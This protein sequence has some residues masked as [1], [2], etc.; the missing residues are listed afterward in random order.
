MEPKQS[1]S[2]NILLERTF[3]NTYPL[4][5]LFCFVEVLCEPMYLFQPSVNKEELKEYLNLIDVGETKTLEIKL[6]QWIKQGNT[7][8]E[9]SNTESN[10]LTA[11][12]NLVYTYLQKSAKLSETAEHNP[13]FLDFIREYST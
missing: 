11:C 4:G 8:I 13:V 3:E 6:L 5:L 10:V 9:L 1:C 2:K 12:C 7:F